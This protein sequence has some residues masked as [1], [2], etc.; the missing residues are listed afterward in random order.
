MAFVYTT[1]VLVVNV[2]IYTLF[3]P[4]L[5]KGRTWRHLTIASS[6]RPLWASTIMWT[7]F[8]WASLHKSALNWKIRSARGT[9]SG[10]GVVPARRTGT[11]PLWVEL[12]LTNHTGAPERPPASRWRVSLGKSGHEIQNRS[13]VKTYMCSKNKLSKRNGQIFIFFI[14]QK[15]NS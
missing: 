14:S 9:C 11:S 4:L 7:N 10:R 5:Q 13:H 12:G 1:T 15:E 8:L 3:S 2:T 6:S